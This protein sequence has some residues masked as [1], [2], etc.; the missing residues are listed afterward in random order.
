MSIAKIGIVEYDLSN[1]TQREHYWNAAARQALVGKKIVAVNY[2][3]AKEAEDMGWE[4]QRPVVIE[5]SDGT[6]LIPQSDD[7]GNGGGAIS[8][9]APAK[10]KLVSQ[11]LPTLS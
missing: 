8:L 5:L 9:S 11:I 10:V 2:I 1:P 6:Q 3:S 7:E 4:G